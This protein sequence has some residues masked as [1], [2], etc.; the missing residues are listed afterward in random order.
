VTRYPIREALLRL[1]VRPY[2]ERRTDGFVSG[3]VYVGGF[4]DEDTI[5]LGT[6]DYRVDD[7]GS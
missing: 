3:D 2:L 6:G 7:D 4:P 1:V 5:D